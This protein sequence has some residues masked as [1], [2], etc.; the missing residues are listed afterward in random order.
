[1][2]RFNDKMVQL[3]NDLVKTSELSKKYNTPL[4]NI[5]LKLAEEVG[6]LSQAYLKYS[7][8]VNAS[9][10]ASSNKDALLEESA[11]VLLVITDILNKIIENEE[12][13]HKV[14]EILEKKNEK[15]LSKLK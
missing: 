2:L 4:A 6:E 3:L 1:M 13:Y 11:D 8:S 14:L 7:G 10:S 5:I 9:K 15:W 12:E